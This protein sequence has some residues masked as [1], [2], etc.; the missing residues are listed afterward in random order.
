MSGEIGFQA[1]RVLERVEG[2]RE[3]FTDVVFVER[4]ERLTTRLAVAEKDATK[5]KGRGQK[6]KER[7]DH[8]AAARMLQEHLDARGRL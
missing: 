3:E 1:R 5:K 2:L 8:L 6:K 7:V 4:D